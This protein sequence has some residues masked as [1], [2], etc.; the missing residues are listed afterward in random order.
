MITK[1]QSKTIIETFRNP[2]GYWLNQIKQDEVSSFNGII[3]IE[4][5]KVTIEKIEE[6]IEILQQRI[7]YLWDNFDNYHHFEPIK[8]MAEK[9]NYELKGSAGCFRKK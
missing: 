8:K 5:Y 3:E 1:E 7:Q 2:E 9:L 6:P 4:K